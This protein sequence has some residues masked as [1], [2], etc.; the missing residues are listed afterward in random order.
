MKLIMENFREYLGEGSQWGAFTGGAAP[1]DE[2]MRDSG[3]VSKEQLKKLWDIFIDMGK[4]PEDILAMPEFREAG[5]EDPSQLQ[6]NERAVNVSAVWRNLLPPL[7]EA[8]SQFMTNFIA[9][10][11][12]IAGLEELDQSRLVE[13]MAKA[14][15]SAASDE[16]TSRE[17][18]AVKT[19][20]GAKWREMEK[21]L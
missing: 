8:I 1:L 9:T 4:P 15:T 20:Q 17:E 6:L 19:R 2:P 13:V 21:E 14:A 12:E 16:L 18:T 3:P 11:N 10:Q 7:Q 5:I